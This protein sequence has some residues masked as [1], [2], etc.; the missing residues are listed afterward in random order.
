[1]NR[2][3]EWDTR[4]ALSNLRKH[5]ISFD[6]AI[7]VFNDPFAL[8]APDEKHSTYR[9]VR[10]WII[11]ETENSCILVVVYTLRKL[12]KATRIIS[13]RPANRKERALYEINK[14]IPF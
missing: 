3:F 4:K 1:M 10:E 6:T 2:R 12:G 9:E 7:E 14:R 5:S 11:G 13:A 8:I